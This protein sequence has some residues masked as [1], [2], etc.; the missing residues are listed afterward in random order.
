[1]SEGL[2]QENMPWSMTTAEMDVF[3]SGLDQTELDWNAIA[4]TLDL[5]YL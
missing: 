4:L 3:N 1:M 2:S 5:P